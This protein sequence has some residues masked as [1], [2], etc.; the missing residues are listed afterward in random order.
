MFVR[1]AIVLDQKISGS[2]F[3]IDSKIYPE[4]FRLRNY[5]DT[6]K[7]ISGK[8]YQ[9][10]AYLGNDPHQDKVMGMLLYPTV[11]SELELDY[12]ISAHTLLIRTIDLN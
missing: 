12:I 5:G 6:K 10:Y 1:T 7:L 3:I 9:M 8:L 2:R 4:A 11:A